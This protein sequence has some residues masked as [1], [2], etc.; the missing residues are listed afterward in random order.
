MIA[1]A[2]RGIKINRGASGA[3]KILDGG[4]RHSPAGEAVHLLTSMHQGSGRRFSFY[5]HPFKA[6]RGLGGW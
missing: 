6:M 3:E 4:K 2:S 5:G 1:P